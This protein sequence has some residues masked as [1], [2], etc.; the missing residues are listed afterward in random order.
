[1]R[2]RGVGALFALA[3]QRLLYHADELPA[4]GFF[5]GSRAVPVGNQTW[6]N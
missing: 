3:K 5:H 6:Q 4:V 1:M 2:K